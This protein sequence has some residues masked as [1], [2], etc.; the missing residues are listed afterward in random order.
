MHPYVMLEQAQTNL[1]DPATD[2][3]WVLN[4]IYEASEL[5]V[6]GTP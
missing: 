4:R 1:T 2:G 3:L 6:L 5:P